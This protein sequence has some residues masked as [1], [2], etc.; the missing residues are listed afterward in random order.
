MRRATERVQ[1]WCGFAELVGHP[2]PEW[3]PQHVAGL[4]Q[5]AQARAL[6]LQASASTGSSG[7]SEESDGCAAD[8]ATIAEA[9]ASAELLLGTYKAIMPAC[10]PLLRPALAQQQQDW[11]LTAASSTAAGRD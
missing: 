11:L 2:L 9:V 10:R 5:T 1:W 6:M 4:V 8:A 7:V 3:L